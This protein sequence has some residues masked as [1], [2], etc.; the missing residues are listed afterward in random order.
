MILISDYQYGSTAAALQ[1]QSFPLQ[2]SS[3]SNQILFDGSNS[4]RSNQILFDGSNNNRIVPIFYDGFNN[5]RIRANSQLETASNPDNLLDIAIREIGGFDDD[6][7]MADDDG[8]EL[9]NVETISMSD[10]HQLL[11]SQQISSPDLKTVL[12]TINETVVIDSNEILDKNELQDVSVHSNICSGTQNDSVAQIVCS[13]VEP[14]KEKSEPQ[15]VQNVSTLNDQNN[16]CQREGPNSN[17]SEAPTEAEQFQGSFSPDH[18]DKSKNSKEIE[19]LE[20]S[21]PNPLEN[22]KLS[23]SAKSFCKKIHK[24]G[25]R[26]S[27]ATNLVPNQLIK[28]SQR[29]ASMS[30]KLTDRE[31][32][33]RTEIIDIDTDATRIRYLRKSEGGTKK[34]KREI[35]C[36]EKVKTEETKKRKEDIDRREAENKT[37][38]SNRCLEIEEKESEKEDY[39]SVKRKEMIKETCEI[40]NKKQSFESNEKVTNENQIKTTE[41]EIERKVE[42]VEKNISLKLS[43]L[44]KCLKKTSPEMFSCSNCGKK[45]KFETFLKVH[46]KRP[47][48]NN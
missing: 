10:I 24:L 16:S 6:K 15:N 20:R 34:R 13:T 33:E 26:P 14:N 23:E 40:D 45:Y 35:N 17:L 25:R 9:K 38:E 19:S 21:N 3:Q 44:R 30:N 31:N 37:T 12:Q 29:Q 18:Q 42:E 32:R 5:Y 43:E 1:V 47:C 7:V 28:E 8:K 48:G 41:K 36:N 11:L 4:D 39:D 27:S 2:L 22:I 46:N